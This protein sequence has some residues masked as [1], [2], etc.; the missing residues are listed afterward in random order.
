MQAVSRPQAPGHLTFRNAE[1]HPR[2][3]PVAVAGSMRFAERCLAVGTAASQKSARGWVAHHNHPGDCT[4]SGWAAVLGFVHRT[5]VQQLPCSVD[6]LKRCCLCAGGCVV[7]VRSV[8]KERR[9]SVTADGQGCIACLHVVRVINCFSPIRRDRRR[10]K[11][12]LIMHAAATQH[13]CQ[14]VVHDKKLVHGGSGHFAETS[15]CAM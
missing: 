1:A 13:N 9:D 14:A 3:T 7:A 4:S 8:D 11:K 15:R 10:S 6:S 12:Q 5:P 2:L